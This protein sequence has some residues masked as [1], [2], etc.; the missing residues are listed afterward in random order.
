MLASFRSGTVATPAN[1]A[2]LRDEAAQLR[3]DREVAAVAPPR[4]SRDGRAAL[5]AVQPRH[6]PE[7][8]PARALVERLRQGGTALDRVADVHVGGA[9]ASVQDFKD[10]VSSSMW[11]ILVLPA[12]SACCPTG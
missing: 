9:T 6:D 3:R 11:K 5:L 8:A 2:A 7:S 4:I 10:L 12:Q 1:R